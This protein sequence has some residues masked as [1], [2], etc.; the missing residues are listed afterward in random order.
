MV[1]PYLA[2][3]KEEPLR[4]V[5]G[6]EVDIDFEI[7]GVPLLAKIDRIGGDASTLEGASEIAITDYKTV[8]DANPRALSLQ[9]AI[10]DGKEIQLVTY[11]QA[12]LAHHK[13]APAYLGKVFLKHRSPWRPGT[14]QVLLKVAN[15]QPE[16]GDEWNGRDGRKMTDRAWVSPA[17]LD[18]AWAAIR[19]EIR[20][21]FRAERDRFEITP[22][23]AV[24]E[25][26]AFK[27]VCGKEER[28]GASD[29]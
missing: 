20:E 21:I 14:L 29:S 11:Y 8:K 5:V 25:Y 24:C 16:K 10:T 26:C 7:D 9:K 23:A 27:S 2:M 19:A 17:H 1:G 3:L 15:E 4:F 18:D 6:R 22:S 28:S 13:R 12:F